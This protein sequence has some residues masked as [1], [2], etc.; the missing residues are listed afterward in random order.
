MT[1]LPSPCW[2]AVIRLAGSDELVFVRDRTVWAADPDLSRHP[3]RPDD[4]LIDSRGRC[5]TLDF[6]RTTRSVV[7]HDSG[8]VLDL[9]S[10]AALVQG[11]VFAHA[12]TCVAKVA[13][14]S[15]REGMRVVEHLGD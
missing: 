5:F 6:D 7:V 4:R 11:H 12:Q 15:Y 3:F 14:T 10:F 2:P 13:L 8:S 1:V 9:A